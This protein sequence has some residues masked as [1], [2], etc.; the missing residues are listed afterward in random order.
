MLAEATN[1]PTEYTQEIV[2]IWATPEEQTHCKAVP[3][4]DVQHQQLSSGAT[5]IT[6]YGQIRQSAQ[7][8]MMQLDRLSS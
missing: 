6:L 3:G 4:T 1:I 2:N 5:L 8:V 7:T